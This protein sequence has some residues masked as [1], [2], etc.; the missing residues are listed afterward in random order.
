VAEE[1]APRA[2]LQ[3]T[4]GEAILAARAREE[5]LGKDDDVAV[6]FAERRERQ[7]DH[8]EPV[9]H[10]LAEAAVAYLGRQ[11]RIGGADDP[12]VDRLASA[13]RRAGAPPG[14]SSTLSSFAWSASLRSPISSRK[15][16]P[17]CAVWNSPGF[18]WRASV[19]APRS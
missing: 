18:A 16:A 9:V 14:L 5:V 3:G 12:G 11:I 4:R 6:P 1:P 17:R 7:R 2:G 19:N 8:R 15:I 10:V 13:W